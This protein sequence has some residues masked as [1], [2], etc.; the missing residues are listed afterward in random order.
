MAQA[1]TGVQIDGKYLIYFIFSGENFVFLMAIQFFRGKK[2][3]MQYQR[4]VMRLPI[5]FSAFF[6]AINPLP[7]IFWTKEDIHFVWFEFEYFATFRLATHT[8]KDRFQFQYFQQQW[9]NFGSF[10]KRSPIENE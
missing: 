10:S 3:L 5:F 7:V 9:K 1:A 6:L 2:E 8:K 4:D